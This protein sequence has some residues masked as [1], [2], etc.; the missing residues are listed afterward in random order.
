MMDIS[1]P[2]NSNFNNEFD[3][4]QIMG[5]LNTT[6]DSFSDGGMYYETDKAV[7][8]AFQLIEDG[9]DIIDIGGESTRPGAKSVS[10]DEELNRTIPVIQKIRD[11]NKDIILSIDTTKYEVA[12]EAAI[13]GVDIIND[14]SGL[15]HDVRLAQIAAEYNLGLI[16]MHIKGQP[17]NMQKE[18]FYEDLLKEVYDYLN[19]GIKTANELGVQKV[20][21]DVGIGFGKTYQHNIE[22]LRNLDYFYKLNSP[23][24]LGISRKSFIGKMLD[25]QSPVERDLPTILI[26]SLLLNKKISII[27]VHNP[28][29]SKILKKIKK[30][31]LF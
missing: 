19:N 14:I 31:L 25:I 16:I 8:K 9:A 26:H 3:F 24:V 13:A 28:K 15:H 21:I 30:S 18:P 7:Q 29:F 23:L 6:P 17:E 4:P 22:L 1:N 2:D 11:K 5:I 20:L 10:V 12:K 27:R